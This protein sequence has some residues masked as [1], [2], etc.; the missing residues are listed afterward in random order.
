VKPAPGALPWDTDAPPFDARETD[1][2]AKLTRRQVAE[3][4]IQLFYVEANPT[5]AF[6]CW[7][8]PDYIQHNPNAPTGRDATLA[9]MQAS[10]ARLPDLGHEVKRVVWGSDDLVA[11]HFHFVRE[12]GT[13]GYA[14]VDILR[15]KDGYIVEHWDVVQ[16]VPDPATSKNNNGMF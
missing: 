3:R 8:H 15:V 9:M 1:N 14:I 7:M 2:R 11:V 4:F 12:K 6:S 13:R 16:E 10:M 5:D